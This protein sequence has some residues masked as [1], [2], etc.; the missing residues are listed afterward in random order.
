[1]ENNKLIKKNRLPYFDVAK[2]ILIICVVYSHICWTTSTVGDIQNG[3]NWQEL[4]TFGAYFWVPFYM[5][6][7]FIITGYCS[8]FTKDF[9]MFLQNNV[10]TLLWPMLIITFQNHWFIYALLIAKLIYYAISRY[11]KKKKMVWCL[12]LII[13]VFA[14]ICQNIPAI[15]GHNH[16]YLF[17][18]LALAIY[19]PI[20]ADLKKCIDK[21]WVIV[22]GTIVYMTVI[23]PSYCLGIQLPSIFSNYNVSIVQLALHLLLAVSGSMM[24]FGLCKLIY[25]NR[26]LE[27]LGKNSL[28]IF[29][30]HVIFI[31]TIVSHLPVDT[32]NVIHFTCVLIISIGLS[33][34]VA[35]VFNTKYLKWCI[36]K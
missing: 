12:Y 35:A 3:E 18:G 13:T 33:S 30:V 14:C 24:L 34:A 1:M 7:F 36:G 4:N 17:H 27:Y 25:R 21:T 9:K 10:M 5:P 32:N 31:S 8:S 19:I 28:M 2:G 11:V 29:L 6:A 26:L 22:L 20:G 15:V 16:W 23:I